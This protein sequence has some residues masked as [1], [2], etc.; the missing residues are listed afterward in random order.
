VR[1]KGLGSKGRTLS[2]KMG[3]KRR[4]RKCEEL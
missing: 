2:A 1:E 3:N 4:C